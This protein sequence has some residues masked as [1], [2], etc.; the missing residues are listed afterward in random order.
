MLGMVQVPALI[1]NTTNTSQ[2][3]YKEPCL[4]SV[5]CVPHQSATLLEGT[6]RIIMHEWSYTFS[7]W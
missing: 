5:S 1:E 3:S 6:K 4:V 7:V 2:M